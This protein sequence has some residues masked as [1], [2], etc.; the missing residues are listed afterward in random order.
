MPKFTIDHQSSKSAQ[1]AYTKIKEFLANDQDIRKFDPKLAC[2]F[3]DGAM[4]CKMNG[5]QFKADMN[6]A[7]SGAGSKVSVT[8]DLPLMLTP[9]KGKITET[10]Q[11]KLSKYLA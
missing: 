10:L 7:A 11:K 6:V 4:S 3:N 1:E 9:F 2:N 8:V 5:S